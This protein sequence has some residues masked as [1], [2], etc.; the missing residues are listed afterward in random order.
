MAKVED[1]INADTSQ[2]M[3]PNG[4]VTIEIETGTGTVIVNTANAI[5]IGTGTGGETA[6]GMATNRDI[7]TVIVLSAIEGGMK[8]TNER[9]AGAIV[10]VYPVA[11]LMNLIVIRWKKP[12]MLLFM[13]G[14]RENGMTGVPT[15]IAQKKYV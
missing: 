15:L 10:A 12:A 13:K 7:A 4:T 3:M 14:K 8:G 9:T 5:E 6:T 1:I 11:K 2:T